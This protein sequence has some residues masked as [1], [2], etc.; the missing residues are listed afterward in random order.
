MTTTWSLLVSWSTIRVAGAG[1]AWELAAINGHDGPSRQ[2][3]PTV[4]AQVIV[5]FLRDLHQLRACLAAIRQSLPC[6]P[7][8]IGADG[9]LE[10]CAPTAATLL[11]PARPW[12]AVAAVVLLGLLVALRWRYHRWFVRQR[13]WR[14]AAGVVG[15]DLLH[16]LGNGVSVVVGTA[17]YLVG[18]VGVDVPGGLPHQ[19]WAAGDAAPRPGGGR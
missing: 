14:F 9:T 1:E 13:G 19:P 15:M 17:L 18:R 3:E 16:H 2:S 11:S 10:D 6:A 8:A 12:A 5:P 4:I 7:I